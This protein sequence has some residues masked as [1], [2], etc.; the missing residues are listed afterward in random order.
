[1]K[2]RGR[3]LAVLLVV[4]MVLSSFLTIIVIRMNPNLGSLIG[5][6]S[7]SI[8][9]GK[10]IPKDM[11]K[12]VSAYNTILNSYVVKKDG[13]E[14]VDGAIRGMV[15]TLGDPHSTYMN[16]K[17]AK[18]FYS[19]LDSSFEGI[20]AEVTIENG[21]VT[22]I[23]PIKGSPSEKAGLRPRDQIL[24]VNGESLE[25]LNLFEAVN[26]IR[27]PKG[28]KA[29]LEILR[30]GMEKP[31]TVT[32][33]R[34]EIPIETV[35]G[36]TINTAKGL[37]GKIEIS[38][39][40]E[41][42]ADD[43]AKT[44]KEL[45]SQNIKGL[46]IDVRGNPGGYLQSVLEIGNLIIPNHGIIVQ[47][48]DRNKRRQSY[49]SEMESAKYPIVALIN[50]GSASASEILAGA[51][52]EAGN[53][54]IV[55]EN[56]Y[57]KGTVQNPFELSDGS[58]LKLTVAKWL[59][60]KGNW[61]NGKG[62]IPNVKISQP[63]YFHATPF[64]ENVYLKPDMNNSDVKNL[65]LILT[66]IGYNPGRMDGYFDE[67][68]EKAVM[69]FQ[70]ANGLAVNG[71]VDQQTANQL[72]NKIIERIKNPENDLQLKAAIETLLKFIK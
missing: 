34:D 41:K 48:E 36:S 10:Q 52:Q 51:L 24:K 45:E 21:K 5:E 37:I 18:D 46:I 43:F 50:N 25:G 16:A 58:N 31:I 39:F 70:R 60:P 62:I 56:S 32:V 64:P 57:G 35:H 28:T 38:N 6:G 8:G 47:I 71:I 11:D 2:M 68:T 20:G 53:Y 49:R 67:G 13:K 42:T 1:M 4:T 17:E 30:Y 55:G 14:L 69:A 40:A 65:Q 27:G 66:G 26:K 12:F 33:I 19:T 22:I 59:T 61:I 7:T 44:L 72:Q 63:D 29:E 15:E 54:P 3:T 23:A 9:Y